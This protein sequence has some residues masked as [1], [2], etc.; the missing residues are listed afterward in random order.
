MVVQRR[1]VVVELVA[2]VIDLTL[3]QSAPRATIGFDR[4]FDQQRQRRRRRA[5]LLR[6]ISSGWVNYYCFNLIDNY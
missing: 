2:P 6:L 1:L 4:D 5:R 3:D